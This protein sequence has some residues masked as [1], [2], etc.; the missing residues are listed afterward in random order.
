[1]VVNNGIAIDAAVDESFDAIGEALD[2][3]GRVVVTGCS[4]AK[5]ERIL[6]RHPRVLK[7][8]GPHAH[9]RMSSAR[10]T[11][12][13]R[14]SMSRSSICCRRRAYASRRGTTRT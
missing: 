12:T 14:R 5:P 10:C 1:M 3:N 13:C 8:T 11:N 2:Q 6:E 7:V 4:G 9:M